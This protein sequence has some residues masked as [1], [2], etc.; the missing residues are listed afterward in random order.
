ME[1]RSPTALHSIWTLIWNYDDLSMEC[2]SENR[3]NP[4]VTTR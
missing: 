4:E 1:T 2:G 3:A